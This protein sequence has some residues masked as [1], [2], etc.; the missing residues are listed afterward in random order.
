MKKK[1]NFTLNATR[2]TDVAWAISHFTCA[3]TYRRINIVAHKYCIP[4]LWLNAN[5][6]IRTTRSDCEVFVQRGQTFPEPLSA[7]KLFFSRPRTT[8]F[9]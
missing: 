2:R 9:F 7:A 5:D 4:L 3:H 8:L 1:S 6:S